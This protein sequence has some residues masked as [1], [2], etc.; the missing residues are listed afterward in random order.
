MRSSAQ[1]HS[2]VSRSTGGSVPLPRPTLRREGTPTHFTALWPGSS[3]PLQLN[4][5]VCEMEGKP[6]PTS[7]A[8][9]VSELIGK[10]DH[11]PQSTQEARAKCTAECTPQTKDTAHGH[12][13]MHMR[14]HKTHTLSN[15]HICTCIHACR[16][17]YA[18]AHTSMHAPHK[19]ACTRAQSHPYVHVCTCACM[20]TCVCVYTHTC[21]PAQACTCAHKHT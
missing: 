9:M 3:Q 1:G 8:G 7:Q 4:I 5:L 6:L 2:G 20:R 13:H 10:S 21:M 14:T 11:H 12:T 15:S 19:R 17:M 16:H 18:C